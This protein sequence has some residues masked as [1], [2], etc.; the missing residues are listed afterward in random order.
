MRKVRLGKIMWLIEEMGLGL[1]L[2]DSENP[3]SEGEVKSLCTEAPHSLPHYTV[4]RI[5]PTELGLF[6]MYSRRFL[7]EQNTRT[8]MGMGPPQLNQHAVAIPP[9]PTRNQLVTGIGGGPR[10]WG[11]I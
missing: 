7:L 1:G 9:L 3:T 5:F 8:R 11:R 2:Y 10:G 4:P 6:V